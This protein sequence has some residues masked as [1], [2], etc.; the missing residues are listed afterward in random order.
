MLPD[1][2]LVGLV[3]PEPPIPSSKA[4]P[5]LEQPSEATLA[6]AAVSETAKAVRARRRVR[7][8]SMCVSLIGEVTATPKKGARFRLL[9][10][11][12]LFYALH[13]IEYMFSY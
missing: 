12:F 1:E 2:L 10:V 13:L 5:L 6:M 7:V 8:L 4:L 11:E 3:L 9:D